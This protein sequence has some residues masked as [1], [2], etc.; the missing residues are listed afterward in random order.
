LAQNPAAGT[1]GE[2]AARDGTASQRSHAVRPF[3]F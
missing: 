1:S 2:A 3:E